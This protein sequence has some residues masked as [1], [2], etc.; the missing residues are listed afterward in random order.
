MSVLRLK[1]V[2]PPPDGRQ[3]ETALR[4]ALGARRLLASHGFTS[5]T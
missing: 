1:P 3:S 5:I 4:V 2:V